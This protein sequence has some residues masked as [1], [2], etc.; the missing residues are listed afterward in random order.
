M[1]AHGPE[2]MQIVSAAPP[3]AEAWEE[4]DR[5]ALVFISMPA[6]GDGDVRWI[7]SAERLGGD[8]A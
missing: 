2:H 7:F 3:P 4:L 8:G 1:K 5:L 6:S